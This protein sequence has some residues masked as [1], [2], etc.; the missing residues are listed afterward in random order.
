MS[1]RGL[2][3]QIFLPGANLLFGQRNDRQRKNL[4]APLFLAPDSIE[5]GLQMRFL[6]LDMRS[7]RL[8]VQ[9]FYSE[10]RRQYIRGFSDGGNDLL[11]PRRRGGKPI[12]VL[13]ILH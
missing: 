8:V 9:K 4:D 5:I 13:H 2:S 10:P 11:V 7:E 1:Q 12:E 3:L 6:A